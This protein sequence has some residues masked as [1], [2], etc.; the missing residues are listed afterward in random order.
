M[1]DPG[2]MF[3]HRLGLALGKTLTE[4]RALP[5]PEYRAWQLYYLLEPW[6]W[7]NEEFH[8]AALLA[9]LYNA[10]RGKKGK[11]REVKDFVR[12]MEKAV[13]QEL[14][15]KPDVAEL[16]RE[17]LIKMIKKDFGIR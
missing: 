14:A 13:L 15:E 11:T 4:V 6:G 17:E 8:F 2:R 16:P 7:H 12:D 5:Y 1:A 10:N 9:M 3:D